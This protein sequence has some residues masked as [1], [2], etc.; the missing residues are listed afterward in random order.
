[1]HEHFDFFPG[2]EADV[3]ELIETHNWLPGIY[4]LDLYIFKDLRTI[5]TYMVTWLYNLIGERK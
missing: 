5:L 3:E 4:L 1:V 2:L